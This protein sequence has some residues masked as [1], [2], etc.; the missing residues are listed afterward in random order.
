MMGLGMNSDSQCIHVYY[1]FP[2]YYFNIK[3]A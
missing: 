1:S 2:M 3:E